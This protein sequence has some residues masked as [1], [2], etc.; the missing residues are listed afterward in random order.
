MMDCLNYV[1]DIG[2]C[3]LHTVHGCLEDGVKASGWDLKK[4]NKGCYH[5]LHDT[6]ARRD[7]YYRLTRSQKFPFQFIVT[8][9]VEDR[10]VQ[11]G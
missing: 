10:K 6:A 9:W 11:T 7:D 3:N 5:L 2:S 4:L 8:R 1:I